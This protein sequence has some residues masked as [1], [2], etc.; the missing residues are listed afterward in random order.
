VSAVRSDE[1]VPAAEPAPLAASSYGRELPLGLHRVFAAMNALGTVWIL[2]LMV[3]INA[4]VAGRNLF[5]APVRGVTELVSLS[6]V[7][8][9]FLQLADTLRAGRFTRA[10]ILLLRLQR[11]RPALADGLQA[12]FHAVGL[13]LMLVILVASWKPLAQAVAIREYVGAVGDFQAPVWPVRLIT[14]VGL[15]STALCFALLAGMDLRRMLRRLE[16]RG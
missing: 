16:Q 5:A 2:G 14:L 15:C 7:G 13:G 9:V 10:D 1:G 4:D 8:I 12:L 3:L 6:I 11:T